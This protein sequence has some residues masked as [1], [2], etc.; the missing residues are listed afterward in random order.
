MNAAFREVCLRH[1]AALVFAAG[2]LVPLSY[3][4]W[5]L[6]FVFFFAYAVF[7]TMAWRAH[8]QGGRLFLIGWAFAFGQLLSGLYWLGHAFLVDAEEFLWALPFAVTLLPAG[9]ALFAGAAVWLWGVVCRHRALASYPLGGK[10]VGFLLLAFFWSAGE[11]ARSHLL[12]GFPWNLPAMVFGNWVY[13]AQPVAWVGIH[14]LGLMA[15][16]AAALIAYPA[17]R[18]R[19]AGL[20]LIVAVF[21]AGAAR[22]AVLETTASATGESVLLIQP[23]IDQKEK[24]DPA[25]RTDVINA[26]FTQTARAV[27]ANPGARLI[28]WPEAALPLYLDEG[29]AFTERLRA[30]VP[31]E[32]VLITGAVRRQIHG[33][34]TDYFNSV[35]AWTGG[36]DLFARRDK[37]HLVPFGEYLPFQN[38]LEALGLRQLTQLRGGYASGRDASSITLPD[39]RRLHPLICY[40]AIFPYRAR[41]SPRPDMLVNLTNDGWFG[42]SAGPHQH[43]ALARLRAVEQGLPL[44]RAANTGISAVV[45][46]LGRPSARIELDK[47]GAVSVPLPTALGRTGFSLFGHVPFAIFWLLGAGFLCFWRGRNQLI[48]G[49]Q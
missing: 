39:G 30:S 16:I 48:L 15:L 45:D 33:E 1:P 11:V 2:L 44:V 22:V 12:T 4:P 35:M 36:G 19:L 20:G 24:W 26:M 34:D 40:E 25:H 42:R 32:T 13:A 17:W 6:F 7:F 31:P 38:L 46:A 23:N 29:T 10:L 8:Q 47:R 21:A 43:L 37:T 5:R 28:V 14:G 18:A 9:L 49:D 41:T 27:A 3:A